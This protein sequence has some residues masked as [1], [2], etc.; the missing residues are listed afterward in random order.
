LTTSWW[1]LADVE[2]PA[3]EPARATHG[4]APP[5]TLDY[6]CH[7]LAAEYAALDALVTARSEDAW[8]SRC[9]RN[10]RESDQRA[11]FR[12]GGKTAEA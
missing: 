7:D 9:C 6:L 12:L 11:T 5:S 3:A 2:L 1:T 8:L 10:E 4:A